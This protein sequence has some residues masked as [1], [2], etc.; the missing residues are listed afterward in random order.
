[1]AAS[2]ARRGLGKPVWVIRGLGKSLD[3]GSGFYTVL[4]NPS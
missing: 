3:Y 4:P 1:M 2:R